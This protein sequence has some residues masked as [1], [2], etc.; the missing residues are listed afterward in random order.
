MTGVGAPGNIHNKLALSMYHI[1]CSLV[2][3]L[4]IIGSNWSINWVSTDWSINLY[5]IQIF[6]IFVIDSV[7]FCSFLDQTTGGLYQSLI[8]HA[9]SG[10]RVCGY[11][12]QLR[13][14]PHDMELS[15][16]MEWLKVNQEIVDWRIARY[17]RH[18][19]IQVQDNGRWVDV[20][21]PSDL[22][23][24]LQEKLATY[25]FRA[26]ILKPILKSS[27]RSHSLEDHVITGHEDDGEDEG[28]P[29]PVQKAPRL[30][31]QN[32]SPSPLGT[33]D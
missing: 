33:G 21:L 16:A 14:T 6:I 11:A 30:E 12:I 31:D 5:I 28:S 22:P 1:C 24:H 19:Q 13:I 2:T 9:D 17:K 26:G 10:M 8:K 29:P 27:V 23:L 20:K 25:N 15:N 32:R 7:C 4:C 18:V 3:S